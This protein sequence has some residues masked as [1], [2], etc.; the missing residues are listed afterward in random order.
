MKLLNNSPADY[1]LGFT[2]EIKPL[3]EK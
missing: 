3:P 1:I 2:E